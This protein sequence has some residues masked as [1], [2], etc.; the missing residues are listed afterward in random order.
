MP[1]LFTM[2]CFGE[3][4]FPDSCYP[5]WYF[6]IGV[7]DVWHV[8]LQILFICVLLS[9]HWDYSEAI[10]RSAISLFMHQITEVHI[11]YLLKSMSFFVLQ[12][13]VVVTKIKF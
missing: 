5:H 9:L 2:G 12:K 4:T 7:S 13:W 8:T 1:E 10:D 6:D 11:S 3:I